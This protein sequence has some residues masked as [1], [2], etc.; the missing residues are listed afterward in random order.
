MSRNAI[1]ILSLAVSMVAAAGLPVQSATA[2][3][4]S[5]QQPAFLTKATATFEV[6]GSLRVGETGKTTDV[7]M[8]VVAKFSFC[9]R[10]IDDGSD[11]SQRRS[12]RYYADAE[13]AIKVEKQAEVS[14][15]ETN[16]RL[17][18]AAVVKDRTQLGAVEGHFTRQERELLDLPFNTLLLADLLPKPNAKPGEATEP[19]GELLAMLL[20]LDSVAG[21]D[22][23]LTLSTFQDGVGEVV[24]GG[25]LDGSIG[26]VATKIELKG[27]LHFDTVQ[28]Q[29]FSLAV[30]IKE[31]RSPGP[32]TPGLD[33]VAKLQLQ[34]APSAEVPQLSDTALA[35][36]ELASNG[37]EQPL[38]YRSPAGAF[39]FLY[40]PRWRLTSSL[41]KSAILRLVDRGDLVAQC[42]VSILPKLDVEKPLTLETFQREVQQSL[43]KHFGQ[44][45]RAAERKTAS[46]LRLL[47][48]VAVGVVAEMPISWRYY[49]LINEAG[50]RAAVSFTMEAALAERFGDADQLIIEQFQFADQQVARRVPPTSRVGR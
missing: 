23:K 6:G 39:Q 50:E 14:K 29:P 10:R 5:G 36:V 32:I 34:I 11:S 24:I 22:V 20:G 47:E 7:P 42:N 48:V 17:V 19:S 2:A 9:E 15:L 31:Q 40:E 45:E 49:L 33:V 4:N 18:R 16:H 43:G 35:G 8:S 26:G 1:R 12:I 21:R 37:V 27:K 46:G 25:R 28:R 3:S 38:A 30:L 13:A 41:P 44:F